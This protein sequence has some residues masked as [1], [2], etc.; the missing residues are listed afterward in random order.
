MDHFQEPHSRLTR[1]LS[2]FSHMVDTAW[3]SKQQ[4]TNITTRTYDH[5]SHYPKPLNNEQSQLCSLHPQTMLTIFT[6]F[7]TWLSLPCA[8]LVE[9]QDLRL[10]CLRTVDN[11]L[12]TSSIHHEQWSCGTPSARTLP[13]SGQDVLKLI[14]LVIRCG[15]E[16]HPILSSQLA[17]QERSAVDLRQVSRC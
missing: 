7:R 16:M 8:S 17:A 6:G 4:Q 1:P 12:T 3:T 5:M 13:W 10:K 11:L 9:S 14:I 15:N 2:E